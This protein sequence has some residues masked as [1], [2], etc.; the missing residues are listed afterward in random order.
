MMA[1][2]FNGAFDLTQTWNQGTDCSTS[3]QSGS[4]FELFAG[5]VKVRVER[6]NGEPLIARYAP[7]VGSYQRALT[8]GPS[9]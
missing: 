9:S 5:G 4:P 6:A 3:T 2:R 8:R 7:L 1:P